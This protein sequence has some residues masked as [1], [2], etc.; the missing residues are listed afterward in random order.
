MT[1]TEFKNVDEY[2]AAFP[3]ETRVMLE[4]LRGTILETAPE[5]VEVISYKMPAYQFHGMLVY[6]AGYAKHI[7]FY[8]GAAVVEH[9]KDEISKYKWAKGSVQFPLNQPIPAD[10]VRRV[11]QFRMA[12]N[13]EKAASKKSKK[14][15]SK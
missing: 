2:I 10:F 9:F 4:E 13:I 3:V 8:P 1:P 14:E 12:Q 11:V 15:K 7:G 6:F 5:A